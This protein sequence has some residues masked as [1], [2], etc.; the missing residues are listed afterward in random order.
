[1]RRLH[2]IRPSW[3]GSGGGGG[4]ASYRFDGRVSTRMEP[5]KSRSGRLRASLARAVFA[6]A[7]WGHMQFE[8]RCSVG[9]AVI[10]L[11]VA[12]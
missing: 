6:S 3:R 2:G 4:I 7:N 5:V 8:P 10:G 11:H 12:P 1:M 9:W